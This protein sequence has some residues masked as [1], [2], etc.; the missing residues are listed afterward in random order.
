V[1]ERLGTAVGVL[2]Q[3]P[4]SWHHLVAYLSKQLDAVS[5]GWLPC[6]PT[7]AATAVLVAEADK[8]TL[9]QEL[10]VQVRALLVMH[11][12]RHQKRETTAV[13]GN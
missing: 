3:L 10:T 4:G 6:L 8:L 13:Q 1:H 5:Q 9:G 7:L 2:T 12:G 11:C